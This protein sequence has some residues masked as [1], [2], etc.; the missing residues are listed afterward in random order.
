MKHIVKT[1]C[2]TLTAAIALIALAPGLSHAFAIDAQLDC[3]STGH[4]FIAPL[5][6]NRYIEP[7]PMRV[8]PNSIN[9]F[10]LAKDIDL[11]AFD[12]RVYVVLGYEKDDPMFKQGS[13]QPL[14]E[15]AYGAVVIGRTES[16]EKRVR[17]AGSDA[18]VHHVAPF[19]TAIFCK[20]R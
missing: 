1:N 14:A 13:G 10:K 8:E 6:E 3:K 18:L 19:I 16:V 12:F 11:R 5:M 15:S 2:I 9:A 17:Q 20:V 7:N 4:A